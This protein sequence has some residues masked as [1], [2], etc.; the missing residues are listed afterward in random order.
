MTSVIVMAT[1]IT[2]SRT[3]HRRVPLQRLRL[4]LIML[5]LLKNPLKFPLLMYEQDLRS[6][7]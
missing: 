6:L 4:M 2:M 7:L 3:N 5:P 1:M